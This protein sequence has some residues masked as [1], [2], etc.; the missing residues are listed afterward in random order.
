[1][2]LELN[3]RQ[4][5]AWGAASVASLA[6]LNHA[7]AARMT[8]PELPM[9]VIETH[10]ERLRKSLGNQVVDI[11][12]RW[13]GAIP[14]AFG[15]HY[16]ATVGMFIRDAV[17][18]YC[19]PQ[20]SFHHDR[21]LLKRIGL[22]T[23]FLK[24]SQHANGTID[25]PATNFS[26]PPDTAFVV[27]SV[28]TAATLAR[29]HH[30]KSILN[31]LQEFL[32]LAG[33]ALRLGGVHTPNHRWVICAALAQINE[34]FPKEGYVTRINQWLAE[35][36]DIDDEGQFTERSTAGY[37]TIVDSALVVMAHKLKRPDLLEP[38]RKNLNAMAFLLH[39]DGEVVTEISSRQDLDTRA[40]M[41]GYWFPLRYLAGLDGNGLFASMLALLKPEHAE[42]HRLMEYTE[43]SLQLPAY[44]AIPDNYEREYALA[45]VTRI[46]RG[47]TSATIFHHNNSHWFSMRNGGAVIK[48]IRF[49][50]AFFGKGQFVPSLFERRE[51]GYYFKQTLEGRYLQPIEDASLLPVLNNRWSALTPRRKTSDNCKLIYEASIRETALG[52]Q[53]FISAKGT[54]N[55]P[56]TV[57]INLREGG[58]LLGAR[59][60]PGQPGAFILTEDTVTYSVDNESLRI[61]PGKCEHTW[62]E[63]RGAQ[64]RLSGPSLFITGYT[65]FE[66]LLKIEIQP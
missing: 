10:D 17:A 19:L 58:E 42:L 63:L 55:V 27:H 11:A 24:R 18:A 52:F 14:D 66:H 46:R 21:E 62:L 32:T 26:S 43:C 41:S 3:R 15:I 57:E 33:E 45:G 25:L 23:D 44:E 12:D 60:V 47:R 49:A 8:S 39:P 38:V 35:G 50:S 1:M 59:E 7:D 5:M 37:N 29:R 13:L 48:S 2:T 16:C 30:V 20:S 54:D 9:Q 34:L 61:G 6:G 64:P 53:V 36:I 28:A 56:L 65:P 22:A 31:Q 40:T 4:A 51:D